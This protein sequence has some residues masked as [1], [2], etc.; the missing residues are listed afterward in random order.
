MGKYTRADREFAVKFVN[1]ERWKNLHSEMREL[2]KG[3]QK[4]QRALAKAEEDDM[5]WE[6]IKMDCRPVRQK[7]LFK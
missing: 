3:T 6:L 7:R 1:S 4:K 2:A 5:A